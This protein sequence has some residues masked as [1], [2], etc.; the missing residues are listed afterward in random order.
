MPLSKRSDAVDEDPIV[1]VHFP[2]TYDKPLNKRGVDSGPINGIR[3]EPVHEETIVLYNFLQLNKRG[4][5]G[6]QQAPVHHEL[7]K[8]ELTPVTS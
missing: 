1:Q 8:Q 2:V 7:V 5:A 6:I 4:D 3:Q